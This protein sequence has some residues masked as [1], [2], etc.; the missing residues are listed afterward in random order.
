MTTATTKIIVIGDQHFTTK[1][2]P[3]IEAFIKVMTD[4]AMSTKPDLIVLLGD[5]LHTHEKINTVPLNKA[6]EF[7]NNMRN[8]AT[9]YVI[10]GNHDYINASQFLTTNHW[11][12][13]IKEWNNVVVV[14]NIKHLILKN[15]VLFFAPYVEPNRFIEALDTSVGEDDDEVVHWKQA[16]LIFCHQEFAG[17]NMNGNYISNQGHWDL[18]FPQIIAGHIHT[19]QHLQKN[20]YYTGSSMETEWKDESILNPQASYNSIALITYQEGDNFELQEIPIKLTRKIKI[21]LTIDELDSF[22]IPTPTQEEEGTDDKIKIQIS[23]IPYEEFNTLKKTA[24]YKELI[25]NNIK[26]DFEFNKSEVKVNN[27]KLQDIINDETLNND[28]R[29]IFKTIVNQ[30]K[31]PVFHQI[32]EQIMNDR[33]IDTKDILII[34]N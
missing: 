25:E 33:L 4:I 8:I 20:I 34:E 5:L 6:Y 28:F 15:K 12:N 24:K 23:G 2:I 22:I 13:G 10:V 31:D 27:Q 16:N 29:S 7:I 3:E 21:H 19:R 32:Y 1:N 9:T 11:L 30:H 17:C 14:D 18:S 26:V